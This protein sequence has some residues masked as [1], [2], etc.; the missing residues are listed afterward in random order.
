[1]KLHVS[2]F[3]IFHCGCVG[4]NH[5]Y[6][7]LLTT[8]IIIILQLI[9]SLWLAATVVSIVGQQTEEAQEDGPGDGPGDQRANR[10]CSP[11]LGCKELTKDPFKIKQE[12]STLIGIKKNAKNY[13]VSELKNIREKINRKARKINQI[14]QFVGG[15]LETKYPDPG[16]T[17]S[18]H[19]ISFFAEIS[20]SGK[21]LT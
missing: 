20:S 9:F 5:C 3:S 8:F 4:I 21:S 15:I 6:T 1:M 11:L 2:P 13:I 18:Q 10:G 14:K 16:H 17:K 12:I 19:L 7:S